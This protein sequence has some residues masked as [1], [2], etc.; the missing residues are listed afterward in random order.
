MKLSR[1][2]EGGWPTF[3]VS[4]YTN[5]GVNDNF[6]PYYRADP[7]YSIVANFNWTRGAHEIRFGTELYFTGM[8]QLQPEATANR[9]GAQGGF[10]FGTGPTQTVGGPSGNQFNSYATFLLGLATDAG[11]V[12]LTPEDGYTTRQ[13]NY[14]V[15]I[16]DRWNVTS[17]LTLSYGVRWE[18]YPFPTRADRGL[19]WYDGSVNKMLVCGVGNVPNDCGV[20]VSKKLFAPRLGIAYRPTP[21]LVVRAGYGITYDPFSLQRPLRTNYPILLIQNLTAPTSLAWTTT[22]ASGLR[23]EEHTSEL[24]SPYVISYAVFCLKKK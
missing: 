18:Y 23:S 24:Q 16:R 15:Y 1:R 14:A 7:Q 11:K 13:K 5:L 3:A 6:M 9:Y 21:T 19:E 8:N 4:S 17:K 2:F 22:L 20:H 12:L 10:G